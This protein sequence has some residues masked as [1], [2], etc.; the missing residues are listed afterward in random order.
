MSFVPPLW[1][2]I[3]LDVLRMKMAIVL[4]FF[5]FSFFF[6]VHH[7]DKNLWFNSNMEMGVCGRPIVAH[8]Q[9]CCS[10]TLLPV[11]S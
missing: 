4:L 3:H 6:L 1:C 5:P 8:P 7:F 2:L 11:L 9:Q 10:F